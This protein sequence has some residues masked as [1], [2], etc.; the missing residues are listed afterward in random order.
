MPENRSRLV[1]V[2]QQAFAFAVVATVAVSAVGVVELEIVA[3][4]QQSSVPASPETSLVATAPVEPTV[5]M[6][7]LAGGTST[8][9]SEVRSKSPTEARSAQGIRVVGEPQPVDGFATVGVT[10]RNGAHLGEEDVQIEVRT[11]QEGAWSEWQEMHVDADHAPDPGTPDAEGE[12][13]LREGTDAVVVGD[14]DEVQVR[15]VVAAGQPPQELSLAIVDPG[16]EAETAKAPP[17][18]TRA[19][20]DAAGTAQVTS[21]AA[22]AAELAAAGRVPRPQIF[23]RSDWGADERLRDGSPRYGE[24]HAGFVHHTV[25]ANDYS[26]DDVPGIIRGIYAYHTLSRGWSDV[27]YNF[28]VDR[29]GRIW[30]GRAG[31]I[32]RPVVGAHTLGFNDD[33]FAMSAIGNF[34]EVRPSEAVIDAYAALMAWKLSLHGVAA[35]DTRQYVTSRYFQAINGHRD[36]GSTACPGRYLYERIPDIRARAAKIQDGKAAPSTPAPTLKQRQRTANLSGTPWPDLAVRDAVSKHL[37]FVR[38]A[39]QLAFGKAVR[40][41]E[42]WSGADLMVAPGDL[43]GDGIG[44]LLARNRGTGRTTLHPGAGDG[45][46]SE[47]ARGYS[48]FADV[49]QL[50]GVG[51]F[52]GDGHAD[53]VGREKGSAELLLHRGRGDGAFY[54]SP[55]QLAADWS[56]YGSTIGVDDLDGDG[57]VDLVAHSGRHLYLVPGHGSRIGAPEQLGGR[58]GR[59]NVLAGRGD[60][61]G[62]GVPDLLARS[63][64]TGETYLYPG[65]GE[66]DLGHRLGRFTQYAGLQWLAIGG[67]LAENKRPDLV[68][69]S[70]AGRLRINPNTGQRNLGRIIDTGVDLSDRDL[71]LNVGDWNGDGRADVMTRQAGTGRLYFHANR[72]RN[73]LADPVLAGRGWDGVSEVTA[74]GDMTG[75][76]HPDLMGRS[77]RG[78]RV[79]LGDGKDGFAGNVAGGQPLAKRLTGADGYDWVL[80]LI[81]VDG[82]ERGDLIARQASNGHLWLVPGIKG[83]YGARRL[84]AS[85]F[86]AYDLGG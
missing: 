53:L 48:R 50:T 58:W 33:S 57:S 40:G 84:I 47:A 5:R 75:D 51:D 27:G 65:D 4:T 8:G 13:V 21:G 64:V 30:E 43:D 12:R 41:T 6:V 73:R 1:W 63:S 20:S 60:A 9:R 52:D 54:R 49:D 29:F 38:T 66:G 45:T 35:D 62:D 72:G 11:R 17:T 68:G 32:D 34:E 77:E 55:V 71:V 23:T 46:V 2:G 86:D 81:D 79:Y 22:Q 39:G 24:I 25:N 42:D 70:P 67:Q 16:K 28:L 80:G 19:A 7:P 37:L 82:D 14:V 76:G 56:E 74:V 36:A 3:P 18:A 44:D 15:A 61:T 10:W 69:L 83:G 31:G 26:R 78:L 59:F 85:G